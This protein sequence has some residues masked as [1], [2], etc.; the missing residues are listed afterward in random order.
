MDT[1][2]YFLCFISVCVNFCNKKQKF[3]KI[4]LVPK[5]EPLYSFLQGVNRGLPLFLISGGTVRA[6]TSCVQTGIILFHRYNTR[7]YVL[8]PPFYRWGNLGAEGS[9]LPQSSMVSIWQEPGTF[10]MRSTLTIPS[11]SVP[12]TIA[13][14]PLWLW[15]NFSFIHSTNHLV[16]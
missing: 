15:S 14:R 4:H 13:L 7:R 9:E 16:I 1:S 3:L 6:N 5:I 2:N 11:Y 8:L 10:S 12:P